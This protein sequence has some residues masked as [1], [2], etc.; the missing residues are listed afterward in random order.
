MKN[1]INYINKWEKLEMKKFS[2]LKKITQ[3]KTAIDKEENIRP[4]YSHL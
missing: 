1:V 3:T 4:M 2:T